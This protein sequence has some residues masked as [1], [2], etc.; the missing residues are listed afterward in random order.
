MAGV[1]LA[2]ALFLCP[3][4]GVVDRIEG[5]SLVVLGATGVRVV[6]ASD[7]RPAPHRASVREGD[8]LFATARG[9]CRAL[10]PSAVEVA[11]IRERLR[12]L[13]ERGSEVN[14]EPGAGTTQSLERR[15]SRQRDLRSP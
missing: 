4:G 14:V 15:G 12:A 7:V 9:G 11:R 5:G 6:A 10:P 2:A 8:R 3:D 13:I 1:W